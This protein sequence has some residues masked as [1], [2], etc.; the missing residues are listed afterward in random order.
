VIY[1]GKI[2]QSIIASTLGEFF[3]RAPIPTFTII[4]SLAKD[5]PPSAQPLS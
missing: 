4:T 3:E 2:L 1:S 5:F